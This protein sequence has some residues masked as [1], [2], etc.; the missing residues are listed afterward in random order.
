[1]AGWIASDDYSIPA[2]S[3][4]ESHIHQVFCCSQ[5]TWWRACD[6]AMRARWPP[7]DYQGGFPLSLAKTR[8][9]SGTAWRSPL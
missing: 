6:A 7:E 3:T 1:M 2:T 9:G 4:M 5:G 8:W